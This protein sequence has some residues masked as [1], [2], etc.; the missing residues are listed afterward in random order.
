MIS[1]H[2][3]SEKE[4]QEKK[5]AEQRKKSEEEKKAKERDQMEKR[6]R[7]IAWTREWSN[8]LDI[9]L[10]GIEFSSEVCNSRVFLVVK[11]EPAFLSSLTWFSISASATAH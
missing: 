6:K 10:R 4:E 7:R 11:S 3:P 8:G 9:D 1:K 5:I 2:K